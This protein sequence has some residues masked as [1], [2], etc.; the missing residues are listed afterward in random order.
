MFRTGDLITPRAKYN[1]VCLWGR[2]E[3]HITGA[4]IDSSHIIVS[5]FKL[6]ILIS[7]EKFKWPTAWKRTETKAIIL[8]C[9]TG[10]TGYCSI[11]CL[12]RVK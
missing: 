9:G 10:K 3:R 8:D 11:Q 6:G 4:F 1:K 2:P 7:I 5:A 12:E